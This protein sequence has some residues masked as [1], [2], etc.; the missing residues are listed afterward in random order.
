MGEGCKCDCSY[1]SEEEI[2]SQGAEDTRD[3]QQVNVSAEK[4]TGVLC[5]NKKCP[6]LLSIDVQ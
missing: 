1:Q 5:K 6:E 2:R 3:F 4:Q